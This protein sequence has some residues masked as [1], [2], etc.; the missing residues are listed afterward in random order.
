[1]KV[2]ILNHNLLHHHPLIYTMKTKLLNLGLLVSSLIGYHEWGSDQGGFI[3]QIEWEVISKMTHDFSSGLHPLVLLPIAGQL[4]LLFTLFQKKP[5]KI[6]TFLGIGFLALLLLFI[7]LIG[8]LNLNYK[9]IASFF[10]FIFLL[11]ITVKHYLHSR[12]HP[13]IQ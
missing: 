1:M 13:S 7:F 6:I 5:G 12:T 10:P 4:L 3:F 2:Y 11:V 8:L 9:T